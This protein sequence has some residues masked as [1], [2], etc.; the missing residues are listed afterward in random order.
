MRLRTLLLSLAGIALGT[1][2]AI[3]DYHVKPIVIYLLA[4]TTVLLQ[5]LSNL[6][7]ELGD[8]L[9]GV[10]D[11]DRQGMHYSLQDGQMSIPQMKM[12]I[13]IVV[14]AC[15]LS[16]LAMIALSFGG[17]FSL[18]SLAFILLGAGAIWAAMHY[19]LGS[20]PYGYRGLGDLFVFLFFGLATVCGGYYICTHE[21]PSWLL[22]LPA[23]TAGCFS[24]AVLNVNN[25][26]D[27]KSDARSRVTTALRLGGKG[28]RIYQTVLI[29]VGWALMIAYSCLRFF[30]PW[31]FLF[32]LTLPLFVL[33]L[34]GVWTREDAALDPMLPLLV[35]S[36]FAFCLLGGLGYV[37]YLF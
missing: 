33:H 20:N 1:L 13:G 30:S 35:L 15:C 4:Q 19:T 12:L 27:M 16:G 8:T 36:S 22:L 10:D 29:V 18:Q 2:L 9:H 6:S 31:H 21:I 37:I 11:A 26:R 34:R 23:G 25:I 7:N 28:A 5:I 14:A 32:V 24:V 17:L 3:A